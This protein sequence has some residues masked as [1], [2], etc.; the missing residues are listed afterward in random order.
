MP[1]GKPRK[2]CS[3]GAPLI[4][5]GHHPNSAVYHP[6][7][8]LERQVVILS[9]QRFREVFERFLPLA[10]RRRRSPRRHSARRADIGAL[11]LAGQEDQLATVDFGGVPRLPLAVLPRAILDAPLDVHF[12]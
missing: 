10:R 9:V 8:T 1:R 7:P 11:A 4:D 6:W 12:V 2:H 3:S 5:T